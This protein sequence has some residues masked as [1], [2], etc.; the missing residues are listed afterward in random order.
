MIVSAFLRALFRRRGRTALALTGIAVSS[1][2]LLDMTMLASGL[3]GSFGEL[4]GTSGYT[5]RVTPRGILPFDGEAGIPRGDEVRARIEAV[6]GVAATA[7]VLG[8]QLYPV[9]GDSAGDPLFTV[10]IDPRAQFLY[11]LVDGEEPAP[12]EVLVS[13][14]LARA[15]G[16]AP[17]DVLELAADLDVTLGRV[18]ASRGY[19]VSGVGD[20]IYD[21][22]DQHS[23]AMPLADVRE[24][25]RR[26][27]E[28]SLFGVAAEAG[29][30]EDALAARIREAVP[31]VSVYSTRELM[32]EM[33]RRLLYFQQLAAILGSIALVVTA[34]LVSTI[35]TIGV[36][37]R[38]GEIATLRA[39]GV[40]RGRILLAVVAEGL[41]LASAGALAGL[42]LGLWMAG[43][44]DRILLS[45]PGIPARMTFFAW[46][47]ERVA[48]AIAVVVA[49]GA[50]SG[51]WP[52]LSASR[53]SLAKALREEAE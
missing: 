18:R 8:A 1:A 3:T 50:L 14:P 49:V 40:S 25:A 39:I 6:P 15:R 13:E 10:G 26:P 42:P 29:V 44:L 20:F 38:F 23:L 11:R 32:V 47:A 37:E 53:A 2:L 9:I 51:L 35:V 34:L 5:M 12:G 19:R 16:L 24:V 17:G 22:A 36:R 28:T 43:R 7:P 52:G 30:D 48:F 41:V 33:D 4:L 46:D 45:F 31:E 27:A 21:Y